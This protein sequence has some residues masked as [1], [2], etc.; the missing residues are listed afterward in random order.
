[1]TSARQVS[2]SPGESSLLSTREKEVT[3]ARVQ[4]LAAALGIALALATAPAA[5]K[6]TPPVPSDDAI[7]TLAA[8]LA[9]RL[10]DKSLRA[11]DGSDVALGTLVDIGRLTTCL[12]TIAKGGGWPASWLIVSDS[13]QPYDL[14]LR[15]A[16]APDGTIADPE[17]AFLASRRE[18]DDASFEA[19]FLAATGKKP[20][21][22][23]QRNV[24]I[25]SFTKK[26]VTEYVYGLPATGPGAKGLLAYLPEGSLI[27][28]A[29]AVDLRDGKHHT[30]AIVLVR[31][32]FVPADCATNEGRRTG[33]RDAG[34]ILLV[35]AGEGALEDTLDITDVVRA[36]SG[37]TLLPRFGCA[38]GDNAPG[39][40]DALVDGN[41]EGR[42]PVR[43]LDLSGRVAK[44]EIAGL[45]VIVGI[46]RVDGA[47]KLFAAPKE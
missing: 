29:S 7:P 8:S 18:W 44:S 26:T 20:P 45:P 22:D 6:S 12:R 21:R 19:A 10:A 33:H 47:F 11:P 36:A 4:R 5:S 17:T 38:P 9:S 27:R 37:A 39:A 32:R 40:I 16:L 15:V 43:L 46:K 2:G 14:I 31:P 1:M 30:L 42:E 13:M 25:Q 28:E 34:G 35:L 24:V 3:F 23:R 41:F